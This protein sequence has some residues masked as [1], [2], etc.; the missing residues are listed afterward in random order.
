MSQS[1]LNLYIC[2]IIECYKITCYN[3][4]IVCKVKGV[5]FVH[6]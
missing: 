5:R 4:L 3:S 2:S 6:I 1:P